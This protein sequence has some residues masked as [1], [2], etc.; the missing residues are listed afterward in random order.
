MLL[1]NIHEERTVW[2]EHTALMIQN[3]TFFL[4]LEYV[5]HFDQLTKKLF[6]NGSQWQGGMVFVDPDVHRILSLVVLGY[7]FLSLFCILIYY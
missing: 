2:K 3:Q 5:I 4:Q 7:G 1:F 6:W